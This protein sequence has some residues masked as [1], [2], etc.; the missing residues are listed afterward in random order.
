[1][2]QRRASVATVSV[3]VGG[4]VLKLSNLDKDL[5]PE[6]GFTKGEVIDYY[7]AV[8]SVLLPRLASRPLTL[9][10]YPEGA[11]SEGFFEKHAGRHAPAWVHTV[12]LP[13]RH[14]ERVGTS[15]VEYVVID[16]LPALVWAGNLAALELHVPQWTLSADG[17]RALPDLMVFDLDPG[18]PA[19]IVACC[20]VA[21]LLSAALAHDGLPA[22]PKTSG[23]KGMQLYVPVTVTDLADTSDYAKGLGQR[24]ARSHPDLVV[25]TMAKQARPGKVYIDWSQN[26]QAKTTIAAYS[27]RARAEP[28]VSTPLTWAEVRACQRAEELVFTAADVRKRLDV[29]GDLLADL[30]TEH[31]PLP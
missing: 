19:D 20:R 17:G 13:S 1:M 8:A 9:R 3:S 21:E 12:E 28:T 15:R 11:Q 4:R 6:V 2:V 26:N 16:D 25:A 30:D 7:V 23:S 14:P 24:L 27:L 22:W 18:P 31:H 5:Y 29:H 10:R